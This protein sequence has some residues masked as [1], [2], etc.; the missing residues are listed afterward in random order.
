MSISDRA[1]VTENPRFG[2]GE[3]RWALAGPDG[4]HSHSWTTWDGLAALAALAGFMAVAAGLWIASGAV[5]PWDSKNHFYPMFRFLGEALQR[6]EIPLWNPYHFAGHPSVADPQSLIFAPTF[7]LFA[8]LAPSA[9]MQAFDMVVFLHLLMGGVGV[10]AL[11]ARRGFV[12]TA[13]VLAGFVFMLGGVAASRLQHTGMIISYSFFPLALWMLE[14]MLE[15]PRIAYAV[16]FG[17]LASLMA[18]GRDQVAY[19][20]CLV[21]IARAGHAAW[22]SRRPLDFV[23][24]RWAALAAAGATGAAIL[25]VPVLLTLQ[26]LASSNR[27]GIAFGVAAAGSLAPVNFATMLAPDIFG[28]LAKSY[29]YWGPGYDTMAEPDWTDRAVDYLFIGTAPVVLGLWHGLAGGRIFAREMRF[30]HYVV[31]AALVYALGRWTPL[32]AP[33]FDFL[34]GVSLYRRPADAAFVLNAGF[35]LSAGYLLHRFVVDGSPRLFQK[36]PQAL[37]HGLAA[38]TVGL[39]LT[40]LVGGIAFSLETGHGREASLAAGLAIVSGGLVAL[41]LI[42]GERAGKRALAAALLVF[43]TGAE[44]L[45]RNAADPL[46]AEPATRYSIFSGPAAPESAAIAA[47]RKDIAERKAKGER[48]RV[49]ILGLPGGWQNASMM[50]GLEDTIGYNPLRISDYERAVGPGDNAADPNLRHYPGIFR[51]YKCKLAALLGLDYLVLDRPLARMPRHMPRPDATLLFASDQIYVYKLGRA[52]PRVYFASRVVP[53]DSEAAIAED[54][55]PEFDGAREALVDQENIASL[56]PS[57][58]DPKKE[59]AT[60]ARVAILSYERERIE[61]ASET[62]HEGLLVLHDPYYPGWEARI[63]GAPAPI[64]KANLLFRGVQ[65]AK[66]AHRVE[67]LFRPFSLTNLASAASTLIERDD[68]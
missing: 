32:F 37:A 52:A 30:V 60:N 38:A 2:L 61:I 31:A 40:L 22:A 28:S 56:D 63:D 65:V 19:L 54:A 44:L 49:E 33:I 20:F 35:A 24:E 10:L 68:D 57:L 29:T 59:T 3:A 39:A 21:L 41:V 34:P 42:A 36:L 67:F 55:M 66:G 7:L 16:G 9:S 47:L 26:F 51:G 27:P 50:L 18:L 4:G 14:T 6:G 5:V 45:W 1:C 62:D 48:P 8:F 64:V 23:R 13:A 43:A 46:N 15:R 58:A 11:C 25:A 53:V 17:V 12:P